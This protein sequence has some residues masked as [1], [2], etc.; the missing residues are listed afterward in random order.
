MLC[1]V[2]QGLAALQYTLINI[3]SDFYEQNRDWI[4]TSAVLVSIIWLKLWKKDKAFLSYLGI[5]SQGQSPAVVS[6]LVEAY[7]C[8][9]RNNADKTWLAAA[10]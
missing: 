10:G 4:F 7:V 3:L 8:R 9:E 5:V 1:C 6:Q 2:L